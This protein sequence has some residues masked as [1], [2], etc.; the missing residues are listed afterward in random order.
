MNQID[1][2]SYA[3]I[4]LT[5]D[6]LRKREDGYHELKMIMHTVSLFDSINLRKSENGIFLKTNLKYLPTD[7]RN[8]AYAAA[9]IF[10]EKSGIT[11][12]IAINIK[13]TIP[14]AA[15]LAGGSSN[16]AAVLV[17]LNQMYDNIF[18]ES[19]LCRIG[20]QLGSDVPFCISGGCALCEGRG[21]ILTPLP[22]LESA[23]FLIAKP[24]VRVS[25]AD[26]YSNLKA[27]KLSEHPD[28]DGAID[29]IGRGD[30][31]AVAVR[32]FNVLETV[33]ANQHPEIKRMK[34][35]MIDMGAIGSV[36]SGSGPTV[37]G[38]FKDKKLANDARIYMQK[39]RCE[40][41]VVHTTGRRTF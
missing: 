29:A 33:T 19:E 25:T 39:K 28:T 16:A 41:F 10:F 14:V 32:M 27:D 1:V 40:A 20:E 34:Q 23:T 21:E 8:I 3:K 18:S 11:D 31:E 15:G 30:K 24:P 35:E 6:V 38:L 2:M 7:R 17:G 36:M 9:E 37:I 5:L 22:S 26:V 4:N 12:G 13:K